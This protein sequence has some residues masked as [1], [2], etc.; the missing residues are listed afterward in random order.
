VSAKAYAI[1][2]PADNHV[3]VII[4]D[5]EAQ[6]I[7]SGR[8]DN[9]GDH[10][11]HLDIPVIRFTQVGLSNRRRSEWLKDG[12]AVPINEIGRLFMDHFRQ[13]LEC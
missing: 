1:E 2:L 12:K 5:G 11:E 9:L 4:D 8:L 6:Q 13:P 10:L 7:I 3:Y